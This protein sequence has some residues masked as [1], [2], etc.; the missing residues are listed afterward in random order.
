M[1]VVA[2]TNTGNLLEKLGQV[3]LNSASLVA[4]GSSQTD[5]VALSEGINDLTGSDGTKAAVLP[6]NSPGAVVIV[7][8]DT[9][10]TAQIFPPVGGTI[11]WGSANAVDTIVTH[12]TKVY[13]AQTALQWWGIL[14]G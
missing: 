7:A 14:T 4:T 8:N 5:G 10:S 11:N 13:F 12:K 2:K 9:G 6:A 1:P 3:R